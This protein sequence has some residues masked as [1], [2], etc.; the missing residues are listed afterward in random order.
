MKKVMVYLFAAGMGFT[1]ISLIP[2][3]ANANSGRHEMKKEAR[4]ERKAEKKARKASHYVYMNDNS[5]WYPRAALPVT[6]AYVP[7]DVI[8]TFENKY[9]SALYDITPLKSMNGMDRYNVRLINNG[10]V[11]AITVDNT[12]APAM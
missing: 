8:S 9:G 5:Y 11:E 2:S 4:E 3:H 7:Q 1:T 12:G 10:V 6:E